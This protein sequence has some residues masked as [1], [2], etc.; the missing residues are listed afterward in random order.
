MKVHVHVLPFC[1][2]KDFVYDNLLL[3]SG[4]CLEYD[5]MKTDS[6][7]LNISYNFLDL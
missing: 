4:R 5:W 7:R 6:L 2:S 3:I 1:V